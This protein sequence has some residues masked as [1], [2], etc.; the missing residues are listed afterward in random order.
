MS[1]WTY[2]NG[3]VVVSP[4][5]RTQAE[6]RYILDT[7]LE[8]LPVVTGSEGNMDVHVIQKRGYTRVCYCDEFM[9]ETNN[10]DFRFTNHTMHR[11]REIHDEYILVVDAALRDRE[12][13]QT[14]RKF[15]KWLCRLAKRVVAG[16]VLVEIS[17]Y[18]K[19][20][21]IHN[22]NGAYESMF[23]SPSWAREDG[24]SNWCEYLMWERAEDSDLPAVLQ[25]RYERK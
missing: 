21:L 18:D 7:V 13:D 14:L 12:F 23:E 17:G 11:T 4:M 6:M 19:S 9:R 10:L 22:T 25:K 24:G 5:G 8:H 2:I 16:D 20:L 1:M 3:T 15:Q